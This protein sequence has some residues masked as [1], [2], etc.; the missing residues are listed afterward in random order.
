MRDAAELSKPFFQKIVE[1][2]LKLIRAK[3]ASPQRV[4]Y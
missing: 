2:Q 1:L 4:T 3:D